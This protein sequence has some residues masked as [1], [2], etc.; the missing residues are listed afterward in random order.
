MSNHPRQR[1]QKMEMYHM[2]DIIPLLGIE[3]PAR[4]QL[5]YYV[6]CPCCDDK[7]HKKHL[8]INLVKDVFRCP[9]CDVSG[10]VLD[11]YSLYTDIPRS[12]AYKA[13]LD[14]T[15]P[16]AGYKP[17]KR[18]IPEISV[19]G[20]RECPLTDVETRHE[21][22][23]ALLDMLSLSK[24]HMEKLLRRGFT[25]T[26]V[27][28]LGYKTTPYMGMSSIANKLHLRGMYLAG[29]PGFYRNKND[30][31]TFIQEKRGILI[32]VRDIEGRIQGMQIRLDDTDRRK[33]RWVS[34]S[35]RKDG[36]R[37]E[38][39]THLA[40]EVKENIIITEGPMK[41]DVIHALTGE[42]VLS[43]PGVNSLSHLET[44]LKKMQAM[45]LKMVRTAFDMDFAANNHVQNGF[46]NLLSLIDDIGLRFGTYTWDPTYKG[47]DDYI[48]ECL[49]NKTR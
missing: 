45:G 11:L 4:G 44:A 14:R 13:L 29:V 20:V 34:S 6:A 9:R 8:N 23:S 27:K 22:Y 48:W 37:A 7:P 3:R 26:E 12:K 32:P 30:E 16:V 40:G 46:Q 33:F 10:G 36:C 25:E 42:T 38:G 18:T 2:T 1:R 17:P 43:V 39:W 28:E 15:K 49:M 24:D 19:E 5:S 21:T 35:E 41:A 31:W 47:L